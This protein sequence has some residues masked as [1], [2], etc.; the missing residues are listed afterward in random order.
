M[1]IFFSVRDYG[2]TDH[3]PG[4]FYTCARFFHIWF[5][6]V[7][8]VGGVLRVDKPDMRDRGIKIGPSAM[9]VLLP[10]VRVGLFVM[11]LGTGLIGLSG[12]LRPDTR[13][14]GIVCLLLAA[15]SITAFVLSYTLSVFRKPSYKRAIVLAETLKLPPEV[16]IGLDVIYGKLS[17]EQGEALLQEARAAQAADLKAIAAELLQAAEAAAPGSP[18]A[19]GVSPPQGVGGAA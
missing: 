8:P 9:S 16:L 14:F 7:I 3:I 11:T 10:W 19:P 13:L 5:I 6:P 15:V 2:K 18:E 4:L 12:V 17:R 1:L